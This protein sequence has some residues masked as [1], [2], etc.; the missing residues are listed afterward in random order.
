MEAGS[1]DPLTNSSHNVAARQ[2]TCRDSGVDS[3][4]S[5]EVETRQSR[6]FFDN[7]GKVKIAVAVLTFL[8]TVIAAVVGAVGLIV[9]AIIENSDADPGSP[10]PT[11]VVSEDTSPP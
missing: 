8:G 10:P 1:Q 3:P 5:V 4:Y 9:T 2:V 7:S 6:S 11:A